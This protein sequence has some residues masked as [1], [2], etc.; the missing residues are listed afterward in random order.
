ML[1]RYVGYVFVNN[2][3][4]DR[5]YTNAKDG[6]YA[7]EQE[8]EDAFWAYTKNGVNPRSAKLIVFKEVIDEPKLPAKPEPT[9][10][11]LTMS[12]DQLDTLVELA[13]GYV[14]DNGADDE[15]HIIFGKLLEVQKVS[16]KG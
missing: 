5:L 14:E 7:S 15:E 12:S 11:E 6:F 4:H 13:R 2:N 3:M 10:I 8:V 16:N 1:A 9:I